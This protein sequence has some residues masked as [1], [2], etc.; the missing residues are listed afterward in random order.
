MKITKEL[1][2]QIIKE[3]LESALEEQTSFVQAGDAAKKRRDREMEAPSAVAQFLKKQG[4]VNVATDMLAKAAGELEKAGETQ[5]MDFS[6]EPMNIVAAKPRNTSAIKAVQKQ[7]GVKADG[8]I[9][10]KTVAAYNMKI[11]PKKPMTV[12]ALKN[13]M[14]REPKNAAEMI[15]SMLARRG[16]TQAVATAA[17]P[18]SGGFLS[19]ED[20]QALK[21]LENL[22]LGLEEQEESKKDLVKES[23]ERFLK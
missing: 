9:G 6:D 15:A 17:G 22:D 13:I 21:D 4:G 7:L 1:V 11:K 8:I 10:P 20:E 23:F 12:P 19:P 14:R 3:E 5:T 16:A 18:K 2:K